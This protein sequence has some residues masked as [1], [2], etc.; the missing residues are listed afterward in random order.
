[1]FFLPFL[2][3]PAAFCR[4]PLNALLR[5]E[6]WARERLGRHAGKSIRFLAGPFNVN[7]AIQAEGL[8][9]ASDPAI[10]PDVTLT[11]PADRV[12]SLPRI[13]RSRDPAN[14]ADILHVEG[15]AGL[16]HVVSDLARDLRWD[17]E[18]DLA[19]V[20]GDVA[21]SR[22]MDGGRQAVAGLR[23]A[24]TRVADNTAEYLTEESAMMAARPAFDDVSA[25][26]VQLGQ[27]LNGL[28]ARVAAQET[29]AGTRPARKA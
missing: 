27:R 21:A 23:Q 2:P 25:R 1:M 13:L 10:V 24:A 6:D 28:E 29:P 18:D 4:R 17:P 8:F 20:V 9:G 19:R 3:D 22:L 12:S 16:A 26:L 15:D 14:L 11:L 7:L 5:R